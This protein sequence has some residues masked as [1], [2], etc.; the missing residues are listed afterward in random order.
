MILYPKPSNGLFILEETQNNINDIPL[1][2]Y[3]MVDR[4]IEKQ[5]VF[6][7]GKV[8][9][10]LSEQ[11]TGIYFSHWSTNEHS[12]IFKLIAELR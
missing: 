4:K 9:I 1:S 5:F 8:L 6:Q 10:D 3:D 7:Q 12:G 11:T 2:V